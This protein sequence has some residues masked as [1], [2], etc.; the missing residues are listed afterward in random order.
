MFMYGFPLNLK[1]LVPYD[2]RNKAYPFG[3]WSDKRDYFAWHTHVLL[4]Y[5]CMGIHD[6]GLFLNMLF[7]E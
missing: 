4:K 3:I 2:L 5:V 6:V 1:L 7:K